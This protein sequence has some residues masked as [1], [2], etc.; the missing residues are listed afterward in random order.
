MTV[1]I[2]LPSHTRTSLTGRPVFVPAE[3]AIN[4]DL[5]FG[6]RHHQVRAGIY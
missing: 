6:F 4:N 3:R 1:D 5:R 2:V